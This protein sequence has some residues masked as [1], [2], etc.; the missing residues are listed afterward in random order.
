MVGSEVIDLKVTFE[1]ITE[2]SCSRMESFEVRSYYSY[3]T[4][5]WGRAFLCPECKDK[6]SYVRGSGV[7]ESVSGEC[8][9]CKRVERRS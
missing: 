4:Y 6:V 8:A 3:D 2:Q 7:R 1:P 9:R 5:Q